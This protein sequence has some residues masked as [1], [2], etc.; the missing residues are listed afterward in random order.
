M[1]FWDHSDDKPYCQVKEETPMK[2]TRNRLRK[3]HAP[4]LT[5]DR[6]LFDTDAPAPTVE[7]ADERR[8]LIEQ[9]RWFQDDYKEANAIRLW[10]HFTEAF[11]DY[12]AETDGISKAMTL[13][14]AIYE[15]RRK[16][17]H[18]SNSGVVTPSGNA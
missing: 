5:L 10:D 8:K 16:E 6:I 18:A 15:H 12:N 3:L 2:L 11:K 13:V 17:R 9:F 14:E 1:G 4:P 7:L